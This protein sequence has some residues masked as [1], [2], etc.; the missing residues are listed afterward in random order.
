MSSGIMGNVGYSIG[1]FFVS[2]TVITLARVITT[3]NVIFKSSCAP[4]LVII[5]LSVYINEHRIQSPPTDLC[6]ISQGCAVREE[7]GN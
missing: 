3:W 2:Y 5:Y 4:Q 7:N 1:A 6:V